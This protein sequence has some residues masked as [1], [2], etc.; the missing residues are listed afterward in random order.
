MNHRLLSRRDQKGYRNF[1][2]LDFAQRRLPPG[3][4]D[5]RKGYHVHVL[6]NERTQ[7]LDLVFLL[8]LRIGKLKLDAA[9]GCLGFEGLGIRRP[10]SAL[11]ADL[12]KANYDLFVCSRRN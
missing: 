10:P 5:G 2:S 6:R 11:R 7:R 8:L 3:L 1:R 9:F 12:R 4:D